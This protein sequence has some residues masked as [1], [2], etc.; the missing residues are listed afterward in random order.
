MYWNKAFFKCKH[1]LHMY[2]KLYKHDSG[3]IA[4]SAQNNL[5]LIHTDIEVQDYGG[6]V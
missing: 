1:I 3:Q 4:Q 6:C 2:N 5:D